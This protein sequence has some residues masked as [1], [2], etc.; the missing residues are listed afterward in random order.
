MHSRAFILLLALSLAGCP[1]E[2][3][4]DDASSGSGTVTFVVDGVEYTESS[5]V[6]ASLQPDA[7][8]FAITWNAT[9]DGDLGEDFYGSLTLSAYAG[10]G[11]YAPVQRMTDVDAIVEVATD[12]GSVTYYPVGEGATT[13]GSIEVEAEDGA[14]ASGTFS[15]TGYDALNAAAEVEITGSFDVTFGAE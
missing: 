8:Y 13:P 11:S 12:G 14:T 15:F 6:S 5:D 1:V 3:D 10:A 7:S 2:G 9:S 4:D